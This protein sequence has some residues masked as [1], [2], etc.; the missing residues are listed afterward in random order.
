MKTM[1]MA[2][3]GLSIITMAVAIPAKA[4]L[5]KEEQCQLN[6]IDRQVGNLYWDKQTQEERR[7]RDIKAIKEIFEHV[8]IIATCGGIIGL[9]L[10]A[11]EKYAEWMQNLVQTAANNAVNN[12]Q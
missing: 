9:V 8:G 12:E 1:K 4:V 11:R 10:V 6:R 7:Q 2:L 3:L 5:T